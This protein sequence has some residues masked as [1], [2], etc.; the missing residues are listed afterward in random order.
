MNQ[1]NMFHAKKL[2]GV[3]KDEQDNTGELIWSMLICKD[4]ETQAHTSII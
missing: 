4:H 2:Q 1:W 3:M